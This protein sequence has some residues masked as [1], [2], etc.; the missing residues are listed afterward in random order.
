MMWMSAAFAL[1][2]A[3]EFAADDPQISVVVLIGDVEPD[4]SLAG[5]LDLARRARQ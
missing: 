5:R 4:A 2:P 3:V 1:D